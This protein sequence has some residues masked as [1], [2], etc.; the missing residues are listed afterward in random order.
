M[1][2]PAPERGARRARV[3]PRE[4]DTV[5]QWG[6]RPVCRR[7][8]DLSPRQRLVASGTIVEAEVMRWRG[9]CAFVCRLDDGTGQI[10]LV[11]GGPRAVPG[12][13]PGV[14]CTVEATAQDNGR[15]L[16]LWQPFYRFEP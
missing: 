9:T 10:P 8:A 6:G 1:A 14:R 16:F 5:Q 13:R 11:F 3:A 12:M 7:I 15:S 2:P 4:P